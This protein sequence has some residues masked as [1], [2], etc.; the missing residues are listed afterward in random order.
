M[1][2]KYFLALSFFATFLTINAQIEKKNMASGEITLANGDIIPFKDLTWK[3]DKAH[4]LNFQSKQMEEL[5]DAS[6]K[7]IVE[8]EVKEPEAKVNPVAQIVDKLYRPDYP[9]GVY[10]TKEEFLNKKP[11][12]QKTLVKRGLY[13]MDKPLASKEDSSCFFYDQ[14]KN[15]K[16]KNVFAVVSDGILYFNAASILRNRNKTDRAQDTDTPNA[17]VRVKEGG[18]NYLYMEMILGNLWAKGFAYGTGGGV[19]A[20]LMNDINV[21]KGIVWDYKNQEFN[22]FKNCEDYNSFIKDKS[23][24]DVQKCEK[25]QPNMDQVRLA[26]A[27]VK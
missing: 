24:E 14:A 10:A 27:K 3:N 22:I 18:D 1:K 26:I 2:K 21:T 12:I 6:I 8:K 19:A 25:Q 20:A 9:E 16:L 23:A 7:S 5:Y 4:Y 13:G 11:S 15:T 17:F